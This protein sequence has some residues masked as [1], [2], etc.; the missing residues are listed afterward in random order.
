M[1]NSIN[2]NLKYFIMKMS[3]TKPIKNTMRKSPLKQ[4]DVAG[5]VSAATNAARKGLEAKTAKAKA[6]KKLVSEEKT[7]KS[8][9]RPTGK[10]NT[11]KSPAMQLKISKMGK[12]KKC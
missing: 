10:P 12:G 11:K 5:A 7:V 4:V 8:T 1:R 2:Y 3:G 6:A 9:P